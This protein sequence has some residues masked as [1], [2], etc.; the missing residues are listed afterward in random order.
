MDKFVSFLNKC[1]NF[2]TSTQKF[3]KS[4]GKRKNPKSLYN[5]NREEHVDSRQ[6]SAYTFTFQFNPKYIADISEVST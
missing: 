4:Y 5:T 6:G 2:V 1:I 3:L